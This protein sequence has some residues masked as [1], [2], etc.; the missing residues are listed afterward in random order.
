[1]AYRRRAPRRKAGG[2]PRRRWVRKGRRAN[3]GK[4][5]ALK[6]STVPD[7]LILRMKYIDNIVLSGT[8]GASRMFRLN[9]IYDPDTA[10]TTGH[11]PLGYDQWSTFYTKYR[12]FKADVVLKIVNTS[13]NNADAEQIGFLAT[14]DNSIQYGDAF[15]EQ[16]HCKRVMVSGRGGMDRATL[17]YTVNMPRICGQAPVVYRS[18]EDTGAAFGYNPVEQVL[19]TIMARPIDGASV[20]LISV[21]VFIQYYVELYDRVPVSISVPDGKNAELPGGDD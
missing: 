19:G 8:G 5:V 2:R 3:G 14:S 12:V 4:I 18:N 21:E 1:M 20:T 6:T 17:K 9:S 16:P 15:F 7:R 10:I 13:S 11:Q